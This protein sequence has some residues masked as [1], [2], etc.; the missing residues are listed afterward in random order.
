MCNE[1]N[2]LN[3]VAAVV[4][5]FFYDGGVTSCRL[6][7]KQSVLGWSMRPQGLRAWVHLQKEAA[8]AVFLYYF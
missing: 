4:C 3:V 7:Q 1:L 2:D 5:Q 6:C 8:L